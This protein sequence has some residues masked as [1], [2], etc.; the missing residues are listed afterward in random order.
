MLSNLG[1]AKRVCD[2]C[3]VSYRIEQEGRRGDGERGEREEREG[4]PDYEMTYT[5]CC[6]HRA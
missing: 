6:Y 2:E 3:H 1:K 5:S 4:H